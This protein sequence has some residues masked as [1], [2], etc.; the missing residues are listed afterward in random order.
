MILLGLVDPCG[1]IILAEVEE[2]DELLTL[3]VT[4]DAENVVIVW[5]DDPCVGLI[6]KDLMFRADGLEDT[7]C[8]EDP[9]FAGGCVVSESNFVPVEVAAV[10]ITAVIP[11]QRIF[12][13]GI[14]V[15][16]ADLV[17][18]V[19]NRNTALGEEEGVKH[20]IQ[21]DRAVELVIIHLIFGSF[22]TAQG[23]G[24][25]A[26]AGVAQAGIIVVEFTAG[27]TVIA[28]AGQ[29]IIE[30]FLVCDFF[31]AELL[32]E[33]V[34]QSPADIIV[35]AQIVEESIVVRQGEYCLHLV[36]EKPYIV[37]RHGVPGAGHSRDIIEHVALGFLDRSEIRNDL[38]GLHND[39]TQEKGAGADDLGCHAHQ[40]DKSVD[41]RQVAAVGSQFLPDIRSRVKTDDIDAVIAQIQHICG[42]IIEDDRIRVIE[43]PLIGIEG[44]HDDL[45]SFFAPG[46]VTGSGL[47]EDLGH[48]F[49][50]FAG[51]CPV[52]IEEISVLVFLLTCAGALGPLV[53]LTGVVHDEVQADAHAAVV[54]LVTQLRKIFHGAQSRLDLAE[55]CNCISSVASACRALQ[56]GH[57][58]YVV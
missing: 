30:I 28:L 26:E 27:I 32:E 20:D 42:H 1:L 13:V 46:E 18:A 6:V 31:H 12:M 52:I 14:I 37:G 5:L 41:L 22:D 25:A 7:Q 10:Q 39:F 4:A 34:V 23:G 15:L 45:A 40:A 17:T 24:C 48:G 21:A 8:V 44:G 58:V 33:L 43:V 56:Q 36:A 16:L 47:R 9:A 11:L 55:V 29:I 53:V 3:V 38:G 54:A 50:K 57:Q 2:S 19:E 49:F 35:A 51:N